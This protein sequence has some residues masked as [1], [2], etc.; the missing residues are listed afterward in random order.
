MWLCFLLH[1]NVLDRMAYG[2]MTRIKHPTNKFERKV[3]EE[4]KHSGIKTA[5]HLRRIKKEELKDQETQSELSSY[6]RI[7]GLRGQPESS[8]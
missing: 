8:H 5:S 6:A 7:L 1:S 4:K 2:T 3:I